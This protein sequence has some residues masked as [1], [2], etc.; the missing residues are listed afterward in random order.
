[1]PRNRRSTLVTALAG[2]SL[3]ALACAATLTGS[4]QAA[5]VSTWEKVAQCES[6]GNWQINT[7]NGLYGGL[8]FMASTWQAYGGTTYAP[9]ADLAT[10]QQQI[11]IAEKVLRAAGPGQWDCAAQAGLTNDGVDPYPTTPPSSPPPVP[12]AQ[13]GQTA[14]VMI[15]GTAHVFEVTSDGHL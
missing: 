5:S 14:S 9:R 6:G 3:T 10:E 13:S 1:M 2:A 15:N 7:G 11:L 4:A 12:G 8:Q